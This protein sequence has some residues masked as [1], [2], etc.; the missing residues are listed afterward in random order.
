MNF[1]AIQTPKEDRSV[2]LVITPIGVP[3][4]AV[5]GQRLTG[6]CS[7]PAFASTIRA[8]AM[9]WLTVVMV[10]G[11][12]T[13]C[14]VKLAPDYD[15]SI[16]DG[17]GNLNQEIM[18]FFA[19]VSNGTKAQTFSE[20]EATYNA[21]IGKLDALKIQSDARPTPQPYILQVFGIGQSL[22]DPEGIEQLE[23]PTGGIVATMN[24]TMTKMRDTDRLQGVTAL[25]VQAFKGNITISMD[26]V[27]TYE[28]ALE[29]EE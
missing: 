6:Q 18:T 16:I 22:E 4:P 25:E 20:R 27:L 10:V 28:K 5:T 23:A 8:I 21:I 19:S 15:K 3:T 29:R 17:L 24:E 7:T 13:G 1:V 26:Q 14:A 11:V 9:R 2:L 12:L